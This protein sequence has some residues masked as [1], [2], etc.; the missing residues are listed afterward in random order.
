MGSFNHLDTVRHAYA[1]T[2]DEAGAR[3]GTL[4]ANGNATRTIRLVIDPTNTEIAPW[5]NAVKSATPEIR[6]WMVQRFFARILVKAGYDVVIGSAL[7][8]FA[9]NRLRSLFVEVKSSL[10]GGK[11]GSQAEITQL[12]SY[13]TA[14]ERNRA[15]RWLGIMGINK[16]MNLRDTFRTEIRS[17]NIG[18]IDIR[19]IATRETLL[20][21]L[22]SVS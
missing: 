2:V 19:W 16:P 10:G 14:C 13:L 17:R 6:G 21:H 7:D 8:I 15:E 22:P 12:D 3:L 4:L 18:L 5:L 9:R 20:P 1:N 11:F